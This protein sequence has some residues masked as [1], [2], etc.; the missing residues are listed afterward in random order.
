M[1]ATYTLGNTW[2]KARRRVMLIEQML[3][4]A[5]TAR[6]RDLGVGPG[7]RCLEVGA[8]AGSISRWLCEQVGPSGSV[9][10]VDLEPTLLLEDP[11]PALEIVQSDVT[12]DPLPGDGYDLV[13]ARA[14]LMHLPNREELIGGMLDRLRPGGVILLEE[15]DFYPMATAQSAAYAEVF[16]VRVP[17][18]AASHGGDWM[19]ARHLPARLAAAGAIDV[20]AGT[21]VQNFHSGTPMAEF[22]TLSLEQLTPLLEADGAED[23]L[24]AAATAVMNQPTQWL[25]SFAMVTASGRR[26]G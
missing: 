22:L 4:P 5:T 20:S 2:A 12:R 3:D 13:H 15:A 21:A 9:T 10:A 24:I 8:G 1:S 16:T 23:S 19:W 14:L 26:P 6:L 11:H 17:R 18:V 25:P 7:F